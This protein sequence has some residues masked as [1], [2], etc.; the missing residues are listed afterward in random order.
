MASPEEALEAI[1]DRFG[2][3]AGHRALH[4]KGVICAGSFT[5]SPQASALTRAAHMQG[6]AVPATVRFSNGSGDPTIPDYA[7]EVRGLAV[8][9]HLPDGSRT[10]ILSQTAPRFPFRDHEGF[11]AALAVSDRTPSTLLKLPGFMLRHPAAVK[12]LPATRK[13]M[14][15]PASFAARPY[16]PFHAF[17][18]LDDAGGERWV[19]YTWRP[20]IS[21]PDLS[22]GEARERGRDYL[23]DE[24]RERLGREPVRMELEVQIAEPGDD[25]HDPSSVWPD[26]RER[27]EVGTLEV[28][29]IDPDADDS[30]VFDPMRLTDGIEPSD[31][32]VLRYRPAV[33]TLS[34]ERRTGR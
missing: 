12:A 11:L 17:K 32:E 34:H 15:P 5:A 21:E 23:F 9:F 24:L 33:Y 13:A 2:V 25:P 3:H 19:R 16:F 28:T 4:A 20:T 10:D 26:E 7:P 29:G 8:T 22:G 30:I 31:D 14:Q 27:V 18:W 1:H 6:D